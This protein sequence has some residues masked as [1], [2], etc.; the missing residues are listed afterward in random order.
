M[1][2]LVKPDNTEIL[3]DN[4]AELKAENDLVKQ[5]IAFYKQINEELLK[6]HNEHNYQKPVNDGVVNEEESVN[7][8][9]DFVPD[10][11]EFPISD[12]RYALTNYKWVD[13]SNNYAVSF[14]IEYRYETGIFKVTP[15]ELS[16][17]APKQYNLTTSVLIASNGLGFMLDYDLWRINV[18]V[19]GVVTKDVEGIALIKV[20]FSF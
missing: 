4:I 8:F 2:D 1:R 20:G 18:G 9:V 10:Y 19:G 12:T 13:S 6:L 17:Q 15:S 3:Q 11:Y 16:Y 7:T 14:E 5:D